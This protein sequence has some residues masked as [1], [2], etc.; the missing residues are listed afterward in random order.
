MFGLKWHDAHKMLDTKY[1]FSHGTLEE[2]DNFIAGCLFFYQIDSLS[3][4]TDRECLT[5][6]Y[7]NRLFND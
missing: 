4:V 1:T 6:Y 2:Y 3:F 5:R 7:V